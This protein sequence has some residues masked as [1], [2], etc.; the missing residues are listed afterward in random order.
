MRNFKP[1]VVTNN[2]R[3]TSLPVTLIFIIEFKNKAVGYQRDKRKGG[4][5]I[6]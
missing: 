1:H 4:E 2:R 6:I 3:F 5:G